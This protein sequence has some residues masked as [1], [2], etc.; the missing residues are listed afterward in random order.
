[1]RI[2]ID[3]SGKFS[4]G[5][6]FESTVVAAAVGTDDA[7]AEVG[8]WTVAA[9]DRWGLAHKLDELH[10]KKLWAAEKLEICQML[11]DRG[12]GQL[13]AVATDPGLLGSS[14]AVSRHRS[15][16]RERALETRPT[17]AAGQDRHDALL[18]L[19]DDETLHD[20]E[21]LLVACL[22]LV[23]TDLAQRAFAF[24]AHDDHRTDMDRFILRIDEE[25][26]PTM[27]Y[28]DASLLPTLGGDDRFFFRFP[29]SWRDSPVHPLLKRIQHLDGDG[30]MPQ[31]RFNDV[32]WRPPGSTPQSKSQT[33]RPGCWR[34]GSTTRLSPKQRS[35]S[36]FSNRSSRGRMDRHFDSSPSPRCGR[37]SGP[38]ITISKGLLSHHGGSCRSPRH[39]NSPTNERFGVGGP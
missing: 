39:R 17:T 21:Y 26:A 22:P 28:S 18:Q 23:L 13:A 10:A 4:T 8:A 25:A 7:F 14:E 38:C 2:G 37:I 30:V 27:R 29:T 9:L 31:E 34:T 15:R 5:P 20:D 6:E 35:A 3:T 16:Q 11:A 33:S 19:L 36:S 24:F 32:D 1:V 12:D